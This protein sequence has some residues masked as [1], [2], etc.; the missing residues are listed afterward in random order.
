MREIPLFPLNAVLFPGV[1]LKLHVFE[2]RYRTLVR[3]SLDHD[4]LL[5]IVMI[6]RGMEALGP[7]PEPCQVG[8]LGRIVENDTFADGRMNITVLGLDRF[9]IF[10]TTS[11]S[12]PYLI[13]RVETSP[14]ELPNLIQV[15]RE[16][17]LL[18]R[19][20]QKYLSGLHQ[21]L[22]P[23]LDVTDF[24]PP[25]DPMSLIFLAAALLQIPPFEKQSILEAASIINM[26]QI[27]ERLY[28]REN[29]LMSALNDTDNSSPRQAALLN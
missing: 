8:T 2:D 4:G 6:H 14:F 25:N 22:I 9:R 28:R 1:R 17:R 26:L 3:H 12:Q 27:V 13:G 23:N 11:N 18:A 29:G 5:G 16:S 7:L 21:S 19:S 10:S 24:T 15:H 20:V